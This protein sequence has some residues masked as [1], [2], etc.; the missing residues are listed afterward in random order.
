MATAM[1]SHPSVAVRGMA[2]IRVV[3]CDPDEGT[4]AA[5]KNMIE[6]DPLLI[7]VAACRDWP[8]C[9]AEVEELV[10]ELLIARGS[11]VP[12][13]WRAEDSFAPVVVHL[14]EPAVA[15][16][17]PFPSADWLVATDSASVRKA[18]DRAV[19]EIYDRKAKQLLYL[20]QRYVAASSTTPACASVLHAERDGE[21][22]EVPASA[23]LAILAARK[24][25]VLETSSGRMMLREPIHRMAEKLDRS[26]FVRI[27]R[28]VIINSHHLDRDALTANP[29]Q[30]VLR[31]GSR[32][33][34]GR[35][36]RDSLNSFLLRE[37]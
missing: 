6:N 27:H 21:E 2:G 26:S 25:T 16:T 32:Y 10:P 3:L 13:N 7:V 14:R 12:P 1:C 5:L 8:T 33:P 18:L 22:V 37:C 31:D 35:N 30:V 17:I 29:S 20:V 28:S 24:S 11:L 15:A 4:R 36:Y 19:S 23:I 34:V 9:A